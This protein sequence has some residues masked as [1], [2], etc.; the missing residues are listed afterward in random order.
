MKV[1]QTPDPEGTELHI[2]RVSRLQIRLQV[3]P[4]FSEREVID[5]TTFRVVP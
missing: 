3:G 2:P 5:L 4:V 1:V